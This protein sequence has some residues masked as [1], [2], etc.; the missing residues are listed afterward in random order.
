M[1]V[2]KCCLNKLLYIEEKYSFTAKIHV[3]YTESKCEIYRVVSFE[4]NYLNT[5]RPVIENCNLLLQPY[6][7]D[8]YVSEINHKT[9]DLSYQVDSSRTLQK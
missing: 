7:F 5:M 8:V 3:F 4:V 1:Q 6:C 2:P 9:F